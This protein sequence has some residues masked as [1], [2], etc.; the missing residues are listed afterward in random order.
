MCRALDTP[1]DAQVCCNLI[2]LEQMGCALIAVDFHSSKAEGTSH[3]AELAE[4]DVLHVRG[5]ILALEHQFN[6]QRSLAGAS[7]AFSPEDGSPGVDARGIIPWHPNGAPFELTIPRVRPVHRAT[8]VA[9]LVSCDFTPE[10]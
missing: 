7:L 6:L 9:V 1:H 4:D 2:Q 8:A 3:Q 5:A 10:L